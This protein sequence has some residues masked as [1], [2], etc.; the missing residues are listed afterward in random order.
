[1]NAQ[2]RPSTR[3]PR[4][5]FLGVGWIGRQRM[6]VLRASGAGTVA[7]IAD[8]HAPALAAALADAPEAAAV[9]SLDELLGCDL[10]GLVIATPSGAHAAQATAALES[11]LAVFCQKPLTRTAEEAERVVAEARRN[12]CLLGVDF[13]YRQVAGMAALRDAIRAGELGEVYAIDLVFHNAYGP[14]KAWFNDLAQ[15]GGGCVMDLGIHLVDLAAWMSGQRGA[16]DLAA[17][18]HAGGRALRR[19]VDEVEDHACAQWRTDAGASVRLACSWRL[20]AG[21]DAVIGAAFHGTRGGAALRNVDGSFFDFT[22]D[23]FE[24]TRRERLASPPD[25]WGGRAL[26]HWA[27]RLAEGAR[28]DPGANDLVEVARVVD[29]IYGR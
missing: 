26:V 17:L 16:H 27:T 25:A 18:L 24:G 29:R 11:G 12:D 4:L 15:S 23:R 28:F 7:A 3:A 22:L 1:M 19:P 21:C 5:G 9:A 20:A 6:Q 13:S 2:L 8:A 14:D 10:D